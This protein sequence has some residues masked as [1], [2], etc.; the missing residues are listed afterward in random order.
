MNS[1]IKECRLTVCAEGLGHDAAAWIQSG[2]VGATFYP[3]EYGGFLFVGYPD[4]PD[5]SDKVPA[6]IQL[7]AQ[8][9]WRHS[10]TWLK[11]DP[12]GYSLSDLTAALG[13]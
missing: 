3:N 9:A 7:L 4:R 1:I 12:D 2:G 11:F 6:E 5:F 10:V 8:M 13:G